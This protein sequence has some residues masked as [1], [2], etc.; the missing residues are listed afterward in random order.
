MS[1]GVDADPVTRGYFASCATLATTEYT[2]IWNVTSVRARPLHPVVIVISVSASPWSTPGP[3]VILLF[4]CSIQLS[5]KFKLFINI[6]IESNY[7]SC[8][9]I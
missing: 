6:K 2:K 3:K 4:S 8:F 1:P 5:M 7:F 9:I